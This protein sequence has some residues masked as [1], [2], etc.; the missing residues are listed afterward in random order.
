MIHFILLC[1]YF[2]A[3]YFSSVCEPIPWS[4]YAKLQ[5]PQTNAT[6]RVKTLSFESDGSR[7][8]TSFAGGVIVAVDMA[9]LQFRS[10]T[11]NR[12][13][14]DLCFFSW[15]DEPQNAFFC[16][17]AQSSL[18]AVDLT[19]F[20]KQVI[21]LANFVPPFEMG[22]YVMLPLD[23]ARRNESIVLLTGLKSIA[24]ARIARG[25]GN[26]R[27]VV[28]VMSTPEITH[29]LT[30][31]Y[32]TA[33][34]EV[35]L[36][37]ETQ[38]R[39]R[40]GVYEQRGNNLQLRSLVPLGDQLVWPFLVHPISEDEGL[41]IVLSTNYV[42]LIDAFTYEVLDRLNITEVTGLELFE[43]SC[44]D[45]ERQIAV[46]FG[47]KS[48]QPDSSCWLAI[49]VVRRTITCVQILNLNEVVD[50]HSYACA[51]SQDFVALSSASNLLFAKLPEAR[52]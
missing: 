38:K 6:T 9:S 7:L 14:P 43:M 29:T 20:E 18:I 30:V 22:G 31:G 12:I 28:N 47:K 45:P 51:I 34:K 1:A 4:P 3:P 2:M 21:P 37:G 24:Q 48:S 5:Y 11:L 40:L 26:F 35:W 32:S 17:T 50:E 19:T 8:W 27:A 42:L 13:D 15:I 16:G 36:A 52:K 33:T 10:E 23:P 49:Q 41:A 25:S 44:I 39:G 46:A